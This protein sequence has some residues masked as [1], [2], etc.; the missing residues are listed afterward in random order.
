M[1]SI[2]EAKGNA[3]VKFLLKSSDA[4]FGSSALIMI[5]ASVAMTFAFIAFAAEQTRVLQLEF[6][7]IGFHNPKFFEDARGVAG[8]HQ[9]LSYTR[10][11]SNY[12]TYELL[13]QSI[14]PVGAI[15]IFIY[16]LINAW[17][18]A[19]GMF[20]QGST[21]PLFLK[22]IAMIVLVFIF[23][24]VWDVLAVEV[25][26]YAVGLLNPM[27]DHEPKLAP[28]GERDAGYACKTPEG[29]LALVNDQ[30]HSMVSRLGGSIASEAYNALVK[31]E[32]PTA[33]DP[34]LRIA[35]VYQKAYS[36]ATAGIT[37]KAGEDQ[38]WGKLF[39]I[40]VVDF[41]YKLVNL[42]FLGMTKT[43]LLFMVT[44]SGVII[45]SIRELFLA[46][47]IS[48][49]PL[50]I[51]L[52]FIPKL[53][54]IFGT[55]LKSILPLL[56]VPVV[57]G[58]VFLTG[59]GF[60]FDLETSLIKDEANEGIRTDRVKGETQDGGLTYDKNFT[61]WIATVSLLIL[62]T[63]I[64][65]L[66]APILSSVVSQATSM[67]SSA[68][69]TGAL[70]AMSTIQ[71]GAEGVSGAAQSVQ[72]GHGIKGALAQF[73]GGLTSGI[74]GA[75]SAD[76][77]SGLGQVGVKESGLQTSM[78]SAMSSDNTMPKIGPSPTWKPDK[79]ATLPNTEGPIGVV[80]DGT[81]GGVS[82]GSS[83]YNTHT[84][85]GGPGESGGKQSI[86]STGN[87]IRAGDKDV[88][89]P[90][91]STSPSKITETPMGRS[92]AAPKSIMVDNV[93]IDTQVMASTE[94]TIM[95][96]F[97][98]GLSSGNT[99]DIGSMSDVEKIK[100]TALRKS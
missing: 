78:G 93:N 23:V 37:E 33:C 21:K 64:P 40:H 18:E 63:S 30:N 82:D 24:P 69:S 3:L 60:I 19:S 71:G 29:V 7:N 36:G 47:I 42:I 26:K 57:T 79:D 54:D 56:L 15:G 100:P 8:F 92:G 67:V 55:F 87:Q 51:L 53:G 32:K 39:S 48:L 46:V 98:G 66:M 81:G 13:R 70:S 17:G 72:A 89:Q 35:Y 86:G 85:V 99:G 44:L 76:V 14:F 11:T 96:K 5:V 1:I 83:G 50:F 77:G 90:R 84:P 6:I 74:G 97:G 10:E 49:L 73:G 31:H 2:Q 68:V 65:V 45:M 52:A 4:P 62:A 27:Y 61:F 34:I 38:D 58:A 9:G 59:A 95:A 41:L 75:M 22:F 16:I 94:N 43:M 25:E 12:I 91:D 28:E 20:G 88:V 80:R